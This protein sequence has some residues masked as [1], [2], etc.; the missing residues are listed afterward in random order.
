MIL[1]A[2]TQDWPLEVLTA[3]HLIFSLRAVLFPI[4]SERTRNA[5]GAVARA[6]EL[7]VHASVRGAVDFIGTVLAL[8]DPVADLLKGNAA[9]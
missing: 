4:A 8:G 9:C 1:K 3:V 7:A 6:L 2:L 5:L